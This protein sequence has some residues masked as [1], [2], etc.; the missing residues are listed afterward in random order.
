MR[1]RVLVAVAA[2]L[3]AGA[4][5]GCG[6]TIP[7]T[8]AMTTEPGFSPRNSAPST[9]GPSTSKPRSSPGVP[10]PSNSLTMTCEEFS[11]LDPETQAAVVTAILGDFGPMI[12]DEDG[13]KMR[14]AADALCQ[15]MPPDMVLSEILMGGSPP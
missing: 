4:V 8:V 6:Q 12:G 14:M 9:S 3:A 13:Q 7:G 5:A 11:D 1:V 2:L 10:A 15:F